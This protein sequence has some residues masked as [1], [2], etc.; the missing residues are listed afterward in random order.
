MSAL[1]QR[2]VVPRSRFEQLR[3]A[4]DMIRRE[5]T[6]LQQ[7]AK[8][9]D[10]QFCDA[11][12]LLC[13]C[14]GRVVVTGIGKAGLIGQKITATLS[15][16]GTR[17]QFLHPAEAVHGD[18]GCLDRDDIVLALSNSGETGEVCRL[19]PIL[20]ELGVRLV[21]IS[22]TGNNTLASQSDV[23]ISFGRLDE[24]DVNGLAPST[25][26]T[27]ML[28]VGD[29]LALVVS[30][31]RGFTASQFA[32]FHPGGS[33]GRRLRT[34]AEIMRPLDQVRIASEMATVRDVFSQQSRSGR[35]SGAIMLV[36]EDGRLTGLFTDSDLARLLESRRDERFDVPIRDVM[37]V[38]PFTA[39]PSARICDIVD[40]LA[41][42]KISELPVLD[43]EG[44]PLGLVDITDVIGLFPSQEVPD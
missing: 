7:V 20:R 37:T 30:R 43:D 21:A 44:R 8:G 36:A 12:D 24:V 35:R 9:L 15:S 42:R 27:A 38:D 28:A 3:E 34:V 39:S 22:S 26:T 11:V 32:V 13:S 17:A 1:P 2:A 10:E 29:A 6:A 18:L 41:D 19:V 14:R 40:L 5:A 31:V 23:S 33:L 4:R 25:T 16:T